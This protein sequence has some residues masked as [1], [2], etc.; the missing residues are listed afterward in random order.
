MNRHK[1][2]NSAMQ[3]FVRLKYNKNYDNRTVYGAIRFELIPTIKPYTA[4]WDRYKNDETYRT[5]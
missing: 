2:Q 3:H 4:H 1:A 5:D